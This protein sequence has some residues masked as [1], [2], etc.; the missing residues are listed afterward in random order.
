M[1]RSTV[2]HS[3]EKTSTRTRKLGR[4]STHNRDEARSVD[5]TPTLGQTLLWVGLVLPHCKDGVFAP[6]PNPLD[7][8]LH[9]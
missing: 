7:V 8:D 2:H 5:D 1:V 3:K 9:R 6:P 4:S